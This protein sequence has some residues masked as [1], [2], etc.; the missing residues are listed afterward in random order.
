MKVEQEGDELATKRLGE[1]RSFNTRSVVTRYMV[2]VYVGLCDTEISVLIC[3]RQFD[4]K[5][6]LVV[7]NP[8]LS[9]LAICLAS[10][11]RLLSGAGRLRKRYG[12]VREVDF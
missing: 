3:N 11:R 7:H 5:E 10:A 2:R 9:C 12:V 6:A 1:M 4:E 8:R